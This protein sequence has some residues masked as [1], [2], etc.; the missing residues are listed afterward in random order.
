MPERAFIDFGC[1]FNFALDQT[2]GKAA[3]F[4]TDEH[5]TFSIFHLSPVW[6]VFLYQIRAP[7]MYF[8]VADGNR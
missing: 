8:Q 2:E 6:F 4:V 5:E 3:F 7:A 1:A